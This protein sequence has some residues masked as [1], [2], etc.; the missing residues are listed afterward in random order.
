MGSSFLQQIIALLASPLGVVAAIGGFSLVLFASRSKEAA[1]WLLALCFFASSLSKFGDQF[2][3]NPPA[4]VFPLQQIREYGRPLT[5]LLLSMILLVGLQ[6]ESKR[7]RLQLIPW[8]IRYLLIVQTVI[9]LKTL[10]FGSLLFALLTF[11]TIAGVILAIRLG[12]SQWL[13]T[14]KDFHLGARAIAL[15]G[16]LFLAVNGYQAIFDIYPITFVH[17][18]FLGTTGNPQHAALLL[19]SIIPCL[20]YLTEH[21][22]SQ[23]GI[24]FFFWQTVLFL[25]LLMLLLTG[26]RT[27]FLMLLSTI[28]LF[29][30]NHTV[31]L[32]RLAIFIVVSVGLV[33]LMLGSTQFAESIINPM[34]ERLN[35]TDNTR[36]YVWQALWRSFTANPVF[37]APL[38]GDR[39]LGYGESSWLGTAAAL[40]LVGLIPLALVGFSTAR[41]IGRLFILSRRRDVYS[42]QNSTVVAGLVAILIGSIFEA[43]LLGN[44]SF[45]VLALFL[46][47]VLGQFLLELQ[48]GMDAPAPNLDSSTASRL[49]QIRNR[50]RQ[51][52]SRLVVT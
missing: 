34:F 45:S 30:Y 50:L 44:L 37:G 4:L 39:L 40:G 12:P 36:S 43:S 22:S 25:T 28:L 11:V 35:N 27:G 3:T 8:P 10:F 6:Q 19:A 18:R 26:S 16:V 20:L 31:R 1:W 48:D 29:Y 23:S 5:L 33:W 17:G 47:L 15:V 51:Y 13:Q 42:Y 46:Y 9:F 41:M 52:R 21:N 2:V 32:F 49:Y 7:W 24:W 14:P 38:R